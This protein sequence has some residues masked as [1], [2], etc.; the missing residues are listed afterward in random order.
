MADAGRSPVPAEAAARV[1]DGFIGAG[2]AV[3]PVVA[4]TDISGYPVGARTLTHRHSE[5]GNNR[6]AGKA[7][8]VKRFENRP[9]LRF[10]FSGLPRKATVIE[11]TL[12]VKVIDGRPLCHVGAGTL[13]A[14]WNEGEA[15]GS[16]DGPDDTPHTGACFMGPFG[17]ESRWREGLEEGDF[18]SVDGGNGGNATSTARARSIGDGWWAIDVDPYVVHAAREHGETLVLT[19]E[20]GIQDG[21]LGNAFIASRESGEGPRLKVRWAE[22]ADRVAPEFLEPLSIETGPLAGS[23]LV[24][25]PAAGDDGREGEALGYIVRAN[26]A[27][28]PRV[29]VP[30][31]RRRQ[32]TMLVRGLPPGE[33]VEV[34]VTAFD[35]GGNTAVASAKGKAR[36][37]FTR[38]FAEPQDVEA[39]VELPKSTRC[40]RFSVRLADGLTLFDPISGDSS[41]KQTRAASDAPAASRVLPAVRGEILGFQ[42][43]IQLA[44]GVERLEGVGVAASDLVG[45]D[46]AR[47]TAGNFEFHRQHYV[48][49]GEHWIADVLPMLSAGQAISVPSQANISGQRMA[50]IYADLLVDKT[51]APGVYTGE[52]AVLCGEE[53]ASC[54]LAVVVRDVTLPD[55]LSFVIEMNAY[56]HTNDLKVFHETF[57]LLHKHRLSYNAL[58]Y[59]HSRP[60]SFTTP[61]LNLDEKPDIPGRDA[62]VTDWS[63][64]DKYYGPLFSGEITRDLPRSGEPASHWY[65]PFHCGWPYR[66]EKVNPHLWEGRAAP[67]DDEEAYKEWVNQLALSDPLIEEHFDEHWR[68][69][70]AAIAREFREHFREQ[71]WTK[72]SMQVFNNHKYYFASGSQSLWTMDEPQYARDYRALETQYGIVGDALEG[73]GINAALRSDISRPQFAGDR[74]DRSL[75]LMVVSGA[76]ELY[77]RM[78]EEMVMARGARLWWYGGGGETDSDPA[79]YVALFL[80]RWSGGCDGGMPVYTTFAGNNDWN[81]TDSLRVVRFAPTTNMPT[82]SFRMKAY[83]RAQQDM[84]LLNLL[85]AKEGFNRWRVREL[86]REEFPIRIVTV[87][88][89]PDDPGFATYEGLNVASVN[90]LREKVVATLLAP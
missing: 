89:N 21:L 59:G 37:A 87:A 2:A 50:G 25:L 79:S 24:R 80:A 61:K 82:A 48:R 51:A 46:G 39:L 65:L 14:D 49:M 26:G 23:L 3:L 33:E 44:E 88:K 72:T 55:E 7:I 58:G 77:P 83:R 66:L 13:H 28:L 31:P 71:G 70:N 29:D 22:R 5:Q 62:R 54:P 35:E 45:P 73:G 36:E 57:R 75:D 86:A 76:I 53:R 34:E 11:A 19:D 81:Y 20:T 1:E 40:E 47:I 41:P 69:A 6:G 64:Y 60:G 32:R 56:G 18:N 27:E 15:P 38:R 17:R 8:K 42:V 9:L 67:S 52:V 85:A 63:E 43:L 74:M 4:D 12:E 90:R 10:D 68:D 16:D 78:V 84:E 30:R